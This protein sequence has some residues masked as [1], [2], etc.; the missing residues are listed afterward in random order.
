[1]P[2][3]A[4]LGET[5]GIVIARVKPLGALGEWSEVSPGEEGSE[6][7]ITRIQLLISACEEKKKGNHYLKMG[8][9]LA[10]MR[11]LAFN[12]YYNSHPF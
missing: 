12:T 4:L 10:K 7:L 8:S 9:V 1:M 6:A 5:G 2:S 11:I 3:V